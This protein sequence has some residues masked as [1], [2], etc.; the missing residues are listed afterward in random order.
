MHQKDERSPGTSEAMFF[1][2]HAK[3]VLSQPCKEWCIRFHPAGI[4]LDMDR[5]VFLMLDV[6]SETAD[7]SNPQ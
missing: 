4:R 7:G 2:G 6:A 3:A 5:M 1:I